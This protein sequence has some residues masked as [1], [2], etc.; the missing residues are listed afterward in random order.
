MTGSH[1]TGGSVARCGGE[2]RSVHSEVTR[3]MQGD[4]VKEVRPVREV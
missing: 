3:A 1:R 2:V 4:G